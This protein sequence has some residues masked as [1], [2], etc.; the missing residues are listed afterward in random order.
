M[1]TTYS[2]IL[3]IGYQISEEE[4]TKPFLVSEH[5]EGVFHMED[6]FDPKTGEKVPQV[7][8]WDKKPYTK[9]Y[10]VFNGE[11]IQKDIY[12]LIDLFKKTYNSNIHYYHNSVTGDITIA[13]LP[14]DYKPPLDDYGH[15]DCRDEPISFEKLKSYEPE[16]KEIYNQYKSLGIV[17]GEPKVFISKSIG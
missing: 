12:D 10:Y 15:V 1:S 6:R 9:Q 11:K 14:N 5:V 13:I 2:F 16:L 17:L 8:V 4:F 7:K 3:N